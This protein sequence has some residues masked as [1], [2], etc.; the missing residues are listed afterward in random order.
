MMP[1]ST[2][3]MSALLLC[4]GILFAPMES[5][6]ASPRDI[7]SYQA[8]SPVELASAEQLFK[9]L[10]AKEYTA[11]SRSYATALGFDWSESEIDI[12]LVDSENRGWGEYRFSKTATSNIV[13]QIPHRYSD[14]HTGRIAKHIF[15]SKGITSIALNS[16]SRR[17]P[18]NFDTDLAADMAHLPVSFHTAYSR[19]FAAYYPQGQLVQLHGFDPKKRRSQQG[20]Q[21]NAIVSTGTPRSTA[22]L[23]EAQQ[24]LA[25]LGLNTLRYPQQVQELGGT[26]NSIGIL[27]RS[28]GHGGFTHIE[29][30]LE[31]RRRLKN[32]P[33]ELTEFASCLQGAAQ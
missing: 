6:L 10:F 16:V 22:Y 21:A 3:T 32:D 29:L 25:S 18:V 12:V 7:R 11:D 31:T 26:T 23:L 8:P 13:L 24:C 19:A 33:A 27:M 14:R 5:C 1:D 20:Q 9:Q 4:C 28:L 15:A 2:T 17:T 30:D